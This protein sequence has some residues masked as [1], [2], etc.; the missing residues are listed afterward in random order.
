MKK[1]YPILALFAMVAFTLPTSS[2]AV[3]LSSTCGHIDPS[4][5]VKLGECLFNFEEFEGN[6]RTCATCH[7]PANNFTIDPKFIKTLP[8]N[9]KLF[10]FEDIG[11]FPG[12]K[13][14]RD[15][16]QNGISPGGDYTGAN[17]SSDADCGG[18]TCESLENGVLM[19]KFGLILEN[20]DG[21]ND[22]GR[23]RSVPHI[24]SMSQSLDPRDRGDDTGEKRHAIGWSAD[25]APGTVLNPLEPG[26]S[27]GNGPFTGFCSNDSAQM[28]QGANK[29]AADDMCGDVLDTCNGFGADGSLKA[30]A[31]GAVIQHATKDLQR[32]VGEDFR[33]PTEEEL[34]AMAAYQLA[35]GR[36]SDNPDID[37]VVYR[38]E[39][40]N[41]GRDEFRSG[42]NTCNFCHANA[43]ARFAFGGGGPPNRN[44][45]TG[46]EDELTNPHFLEM[47]AAAPKPDG[48][49]NPPGTVQGGVSG[50]CA[51]DDDG[52][53]DRGTR[54]CQGA[55]QTEADL[56]CVFDPDGG[57]GPLL[58]DDFGPCELVE[59]SH[60]NGRFNVPP[61]IEVADTAPFMHNNSINTVEAAVD[62]YQTR[63]FAKGG[64][65]FQ[66]GQSLLGMSG[67]TALGI[68]LWLRTINVV[69]NIRLSVGKL[70]DAEFGC[71]Q[72]DNRNLVRVAMADTED[73]YQVLEGS[74][75]KLF[76]E[77]VTLLKAAYRIQRSLFGSK[78]GSFE[79]PVSK[80]C[81]DAP[82]KYSTT[83]RH[84]IK[85]LL[86]ARDLIVDDTPA[87]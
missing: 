63:N 30:F 66:N 57:G 71:N 62:F 22:E 32:R 49:F 25:G 19:R 73:A 76:G 86:E 11:N 61:V 14:C 46:V 69:E 84:A 42:R 8:A 77:A 29:T 6:G 72:I 33:L 34:D 39:I 79:V 47:T 4:E 35:Q 28:C 83:I 56:A 74:E 23:M 31:I 65:P 87:P 40:V 27:G 10:V 70:E 67:D 20:V 5:Q 55:D 15:R 52:D 82:Y 85:H 75:Y 44:F 38:S 45:N 43:G 16:S 24:F 41:F 54:V 51:V 68:A 13:Q 36:D 78:V 58:E 53:F 18:L 64:G 9:D 7:P 26:N 12:L 59:H 48:G 3:V 80:D 17:C 81:D 50:F 21:L 60:G 1:I 37:E 2:E